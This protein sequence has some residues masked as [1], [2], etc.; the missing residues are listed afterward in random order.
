MDPHLICNDVCLM[1]VD[2]IFLGTQCL[3]FNYAARELSGAMNE[4][5]IH[6]RKTKSPSGL[7]AYF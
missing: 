4:F 7:R 3:N 1:G 2:M 6:A 5:D